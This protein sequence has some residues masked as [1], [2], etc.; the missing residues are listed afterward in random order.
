MTPLVSE[1]CFQ[2]LMHRKKA[3][4]FKKRSQNDQRERVVSEPKA[5]AEELETVEGGKRNV[6][7]VH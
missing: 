4:Q 6:Q 7:W 1:I 5:H 3:D 2:I